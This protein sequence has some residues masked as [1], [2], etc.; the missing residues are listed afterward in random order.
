LKLGTYYD[1]IFK[2]VPHKKISRTKPSVFVVKE[3]DHFFPF[4]VVAAAVEHLT[5]KT[6]GMD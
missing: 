6:R 1:I 5:Q 2:K 3:V 4:V